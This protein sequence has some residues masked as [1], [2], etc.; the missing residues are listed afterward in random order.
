MPHLYID[1]RGV[2]RFND[3]ST[4]VWAAAIAAR[5]VDEHS[6]LA[7]EDQE[8]LEKALTIALNTSPAAVGLLIGTGII[9]E[10]YFED[11]S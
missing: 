8:I 9:E 4:A 2:L 10:D 7:V 6:G 1:Q 5:I 11:M 3:I